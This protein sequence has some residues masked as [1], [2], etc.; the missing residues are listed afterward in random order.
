MQK[1]SYNIRMALDALLQR[2]VRSILTSLGIIFGVA[3]VIAMMAIG[4]GAQ[5]EIV[6]QMKILGSNNIIVEPVVEQKEEEVTEESGQ[7]DNNSRYSPGLMLSDAES[8]LE[9]IP[10]VVSVSP[11]IVMETT[12]LRSGKKRSGKLIGVTSTFFEN[13]GF[14][15]AVGKT[16]TA[17]QIENSAPVCVIG[18]DIKTKFFSQESPVGKRIKVGKVWLT[19]V[20]VAS[21]RRFSQSSMRELGIRD[22]DMDIYTPVSTVLLR[23]KNRARVSPADLREAAISRRDDG[24]SGEKPVAKNY[25]QIDR[26]VVSVEDGMD[27][28]RVAEVIRRML[29]R[30]HNMVVDTEVIIP[31]ELLAQKQRTTSIFNGVLISIACIS[32][33]TGGIGILNIMLASVMERIKE[34]GVRLSLGATKRDI[35]TQFLSESVALS[36]AGGLLGIILGIFL[37]LSIEKLSNVQTIISGL[38][39]FVS[40]FVAASVGIFFGFFP[41][42]KASK[43]DPVV[44]LRHE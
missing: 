39:I 12:F 5:A 7:E 43:Q 18:Y 23:Y 30:R 1:L 2:P 24:D 25:H 10:G 36:I 42:L 26:L 21:E 27:M 4:K 38:S 32:L 17:D 19:V 20:G 6:E 29:E 13:Q 35:V 44:S 34:I 33:L 11:E 3:A 9:V 8:I 16:F 15:L 28:F 40:F 37:S 22:Y 14:D 41:A 31:E